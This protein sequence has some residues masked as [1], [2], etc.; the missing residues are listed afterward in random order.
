MANNTYAARKDYMTA[1]RKDNPSIISAQNK[2]MLIKGKQLF[3]S[4]SRERAKEKCCSLCKTIK[5][6]KEFYLSNTNPDGLHG[7]CKSCSDK[8]TVENAYKRLH[9]LSMEDVD[10]I[11]E[12]QGGLCAICGLPNLNKRKFCLDHDHS[13]GKVRGLLCTSCNTMLGNAHDNISLLQSAIEYLRRNE[14]R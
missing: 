12:E 7:W 8:R 9:G 14:C 10:K 13:T 1:Y 11:N 4:G 2:R 3:E 6:A 5:S